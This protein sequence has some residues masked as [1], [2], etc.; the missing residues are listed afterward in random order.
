MER[1]K[2]SFEG[3]LRISPKPVLALLGLMACLLYASAELIVA[4]WTLVNRVLSLSL[5]LLG[6]SLAS[7]M[8]HNWRPLLGRWA[9]VAS[10]VVAIYAAHRILA[11]P[12]ILTLVV[13]PVA[14]ATPL[15][16]FAASGAMAV[17][18]SIL[19]ALLAWRQAEAVTPA[20]LV[21]AYLGIW[22]ALGITYATH[23]P[24]HRLV[25]WLEAYF[26]RGQAFLEEARDRKAA[27]EQALESYTNA[28]R[29]LMLAHE[30]MRALRTVAEEAQ[31]AKAAFVAN[32]SHEFRTPL[33]MI[34]GLV[35]LM[36][37]SPEIY[38]VVLSPAMRE[39]LQVIHRN[40]EHLSDMINDVLDLTRMEAGR[41]ALRRERVDLTT[42]IDNSLAAVRPL[43]DKK[44]LDFEINV[45]E[46][47]PEVY[48]D[49][50]RA[51]QVILNLVSNATRFT[52]AGRITVNVAMNEHEVTVSVQDTG[53]G[54]PP[55]DVETIFEPFEQGKLWHGTGG[56]GLGLSVSKRF[57]ELHGGKMWLESQVGV[58]T[59]FFF[60]LP[61]SP[62]L[63]HTVS[64]GHN[65][66]S[67]WVWREPAFKASRASYS[68]DLVRPRIVVY[69]AEGEMK[70]WFDHY[71]DEVELL[72]VGALEQV[73]ELLE[74]SPA[75][76]VVVNAPKP[77][78]LWTMIEK[79][80]NKTQGTPI[81]GCTMSHAPERAVEAGAAGHLIKP[82]TRADLTSIIES[83][84]APV[85]RVL[86]VDDDPDVLQL[87]T[88]MLH[89]DHPN[90][91]VTTA[92]DGASALA[93]LADAPPD[94]VLL[95]IVMTDISGWEVLTA[96]KN[97][98]E[99]PEIPVFMVSAQDP[100]D[101]P[102]LS[103]MLVATIDGGIPMSKVLRGAQAL[104]KFLLEPEASPDLM[105][106]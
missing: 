80:Q 83:V 68:D 19:L 44:R 56:S 52:D 75:H 21:I 3:E 12:E 85:Q 90:V 26:E 9:T 78:A 86:I 51:Q 97:D 73:F 88:R 60:T 84:G 70:T 46:T 16:S 54:I 39:D 50:T 71:A 67:D 63:P 104:S 8:L 77:D 48:C 47:L 30:R 2:S 99:I 100:V 38:T 10:V 62:P 65:I 14:L 45:P 5:I 17:M 79:V 102:P 20:T 96:I 6:V 15:I 41:L 36:M 93:H 33:N 43:L 98:T 53:T 74:Q 89:V 31:R 34:I 18:T 11:I 61:I 95:D 103:D 7:W 42:I 32:V 23:Q 55:E 24:I 4:R 105:P 57:V 27:L 82:V 106:E 91:S 87:F 22:S 101:H 40:C 49:R 59:T 72:K 69:D 1:D 92:Q 25:A 29:Q 76:A 13:L 66:R 64:S 58:G 81:I 28:N 94:I 37:E 35:D